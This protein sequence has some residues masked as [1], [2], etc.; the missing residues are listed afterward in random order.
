MGRPIGDH[1]LLATEVSN[2]LL[3]IYL[4][5]SDI[6]VF[7][8]HAEGSPNALIEAIAS[9]LPI[10]GWDIPFM[11]EHTSSDFALLV[12]ESDIS[13]L[14]DAI[15]MLSKDLKL[16]CSMAHSARMYAI[17]NYSIDKRIQKIASHISN[18]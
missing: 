12:K 17:E 8:S 14:S 10:V 7:P 16:R 5:K 2:H 11:R 18:V 3:P 13:A 9:G 1:V 6:F 4:N 15:L